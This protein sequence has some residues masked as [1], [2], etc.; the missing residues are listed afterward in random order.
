MNA[1]TNRETESKER[2]RILVVGNG[3]SF[4]Q[5]IVEYSVWFAKRM[6]YELIAL[7]CIPVGHEAPEVLSPY[8]DEIQTKFEIESAEGAELIAYRAAT[9]KV[10]FRHFVK[11]GP[12]DRCIR[13]THKEIEGLEFVMAEP[14]ACPEVDMETAIPVFSFS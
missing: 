2:P 13:E 3:P 4:S 1:E 9:E 7:N 6:D 5:Q 12:P 8:Q 14:E 10:P 11:F